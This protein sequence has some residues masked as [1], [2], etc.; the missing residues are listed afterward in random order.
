MKTALALAAALG[1]SVSAASACSF[2]KN[3]SAGVDTEL[4]VSSIATDAMST[5]VDMAALE[6]TD[7]EPRVE[8]AE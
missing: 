5:P 7:E 2:N 4:T 3:V 8:T 6:V 1:L